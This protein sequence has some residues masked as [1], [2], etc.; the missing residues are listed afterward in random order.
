[1]SVNPYPTARAAT[2]LTGLAVLI[3][4]VGMLVEISLAWR[5]GIR[6][7]RIKC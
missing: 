4:L 3:P 2:T 6:S 7:L 1:M 5:L